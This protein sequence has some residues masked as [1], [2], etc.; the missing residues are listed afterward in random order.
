MKKQ[1]RKAVIQNISHRQG[2]TGTTGG[3][4]FD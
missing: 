2:M 1:G 4:A 3:G